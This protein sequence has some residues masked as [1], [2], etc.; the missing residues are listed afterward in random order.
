[1]GIKY[2]R[3]LISGFSL[4]MKLNKNNKKDIIKI[5]KLVQN[6]KRKAENNIEV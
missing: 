4:S 3:F 6:T 1:M 2:N 5:L